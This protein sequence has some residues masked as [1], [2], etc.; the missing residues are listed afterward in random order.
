MVSQG[1]N[2]DLA[3]FE[4]PIYRSIY[5]SIYQK[6]G[7]PMSERHEGDAF[8]FDFGKWSRR[9]GRRS[10][11]KV[12]ERGDLKFVILRLVL[13]KPMHGYEVMQALEEESCGWYQ[14]SPGSVYPTLQMLEDEGFVTSKEEKGKKVYEITDAGREYLDEHGDIVE[15]I[16]DRIKT[17]ADRF[18]GKDTRDL[19]ASFSRLAQS[20]F[21]SAFDW[22]TG[23]DMLR[24]MADALDRARQEME[25]IRKGSK[26]SEQKGPDSKGPDSEA[27]EADEPTSDD[28]EDPNP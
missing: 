9:R 14:A 22:G 19:S 24:K 6:R 28:K 26:E 25:D 7:R 20:T 4:L 13:D 27:P 5:R 10:R 15:E 8:G 16:F 21:E 12:F 1:W 11:W 18:V 2:G 17:F 23:P 3:A